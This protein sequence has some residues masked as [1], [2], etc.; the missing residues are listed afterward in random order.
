MSASAS[1]SVSAHSLGTLSSL[2][3][4]SSTINYV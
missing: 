2:M 1:V 4:A 3:I